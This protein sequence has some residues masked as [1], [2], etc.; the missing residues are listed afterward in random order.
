MARERYFRL[1][2]VDLPRSENREVP[3]TDDEI[4]TYH[5]ILFLRDFFSR[6]LGIGRSYKTFGFPFGPKKIFR[7][8]CVRWNAVVPHLVFLGR[9]MGL[10]LAF[11]PVYPKGLHWL[12]WQG[13]KRFNYNNYVTKRIFFN[14]PA[15]KIF[16]SRTA[17]T[18][19]E[20]KEVQVGRR[21]RPLFPPTQPKQ[22]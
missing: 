16:E 15:K 22:L 6:V 12:D 20:V 14:N 5:F 9:R 1:C 17:V 4:F 7:P 3:S 18:V 10:A 19:G 21:L 13:S 2:A 8:R 11:V